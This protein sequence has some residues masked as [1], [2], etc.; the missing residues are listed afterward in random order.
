M[1]G[2]VQ[3]TVACAGFFVSRFNRSVYMTATDELLT[4]QQVA[5]Y[6][7]VQRCTLEQWA[8][9]GRED[10]PPYIKV[11]RL[12]RYRREDLDRWLD[13]RREGRNAL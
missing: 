10:G 4:R 13:S 1:I 6:L 7:K 3:A 8:S 11:G 12:V 2:P 9:T 5:D